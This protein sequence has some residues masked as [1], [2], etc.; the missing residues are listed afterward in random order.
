MDTIPRYLVGCTSLLDF[1]LAKKAFT[2]QHGSDVR[3][4]DFGR[5]K[6]QEIDIQMEVIESIP[7]DYRHV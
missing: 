7:A 1:L 3:I 5:G 4:I 6:S 2:L